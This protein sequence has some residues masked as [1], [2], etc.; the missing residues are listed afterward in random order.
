MI[1]KINP[2][3]TEYTD[4]RKNQLVHTDNIIKNYKIPDILG[5]TTV[6]L[7]EFLAVRY[8]R[9]IEFIGHHITKESVFLEIGCRT[10][11]ISQVLKKQGYENCYGVD[12]HKQAL[13]G[14]KKG[15]VNAICADMHFLPVKSQ[16]VDIIL[17]SEVL[18]H[19]PTPDLVLLEMQRVLKRKG[20]I[21]IDVPLQAESYRDFF[22]K[23]EAH[24]S[25][26]H[27]ATCHNF[28]NEF[29]E[30]LTYQFIFY[31][32]PNPQG[33]FTLHSIIWVGKK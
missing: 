12:L 23:K 9:H 21:I 15:G 18:E 7:P 3:S 19:S 25:F 32:T 4:Y 1:K 22:Y 27:F 26:F 31:A 29:F 17:L 30:M 24:L 8:G 28:F 6:E 16:S 13:M 14:A 33:R 5:E 2:T 11:I 20:V 10:A